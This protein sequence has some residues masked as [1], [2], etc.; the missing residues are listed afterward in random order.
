MEAMLSA[1]LQVHR[2]PQCLLWTDTAHLP[3][4]VVHILHNILLLC[5]RRHSE[6]RVFLTGKLND[7]LRYV[8]HFELVL[9]D[10][11]CSRQQSDQVAGKVTRQFI[12]LW[13]YQ[14]VSIEFT[15]VS[16]LDGTA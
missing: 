10:C 4:Q 9:F 1:H 2:A 8:F 7:S 12:S 3:D 14:S 16:A 5:R 6:R 15:G 13:C 11:H